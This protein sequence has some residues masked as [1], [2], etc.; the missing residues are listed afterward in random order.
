[1]KVRRNLA[2]HADFGRGAV[3]VPVDGEEG[4]RRQRG[5]RRHRLRASISSGEMQSVQ[6]VE[7]H[8]PIGTMDFAQLISRI[9][10][11]ENAVS[12]LTVQ[13]VPQQ[14][15]R[16]DGLPVVPPFLAPFR[17]QHSCFR[18]TWAMV[19]ATCLGGTV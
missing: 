3:A 11:V 1:M 7:E 16:L 13:Q 10:A 8:L 12:A 18:I 6:T 5:G 15:R 4:K 14:R 17:F 2:V 19:R 9:D